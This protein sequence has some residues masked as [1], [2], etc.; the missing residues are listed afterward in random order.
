VEL[1]R[2]DPIPRAREARTDLGGPVVTVAAD[3]WDRYRS[4][5]WMKAWES[6][7]AEDL[8]FM[9]PYAPAPKG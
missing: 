5:A 9:K 1:E 8:V 3:L 2:A 6:R 7:E 4:T